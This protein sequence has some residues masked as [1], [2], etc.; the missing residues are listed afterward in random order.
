MDTT[1]LSFE[2]FL[3]DKHYEENPTILDDDLPDAF[4]D[5]LGNLDGHEYI[6]YADEWGKKLIAKK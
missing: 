5:W 4:D 6:R 2:D 1:T 3:K